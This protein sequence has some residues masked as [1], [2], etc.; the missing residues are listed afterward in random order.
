MNRLLSIAVLSLAVLTFSCS[1]SDPVDKAVD[2]LEKSSE[3]VKKAQTEDEAI[4]IT[5]ETSKELEQLNIRQQKLSP[6]EQARLTNA[7]VGYMQ[8]C[9]SSKIDFTKQVNN[10]VLDMSSDSEQ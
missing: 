5:Q 4:K 8:A 7:I 10:T 2:I 6:E 9:M 1:S 3:Q